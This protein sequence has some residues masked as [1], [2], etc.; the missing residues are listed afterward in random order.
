MSHHKHRQRAGGSTDYAQLFYAPYADP[1]QLSR[2]TLKYID[3]APMFH[4]LQTG[5]IIPTGTSGIIP[6]GAYYEAIAPLVVPNALGPNPYGAV[7]PL[8][9]QRGGHHDQKK[10]KQKQEQEKERRRIQ[11]EDM[12]FTQMMEERLKPQTNHSHHGGYAEQKR[13]HVKSPEPAYY[14]KNGQVITNPWVI[15]VHRFAEENGLTYR[16]ALND[17]RTSESYQN[18]KMRA[19]R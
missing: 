11:A 7:P 3:Q 13:D 10:Q 1:G 18:M 14:G 19:R 16:E 17:E 5:T 8:T 2:F 9:T 15:H 12:E 4:P 6:T